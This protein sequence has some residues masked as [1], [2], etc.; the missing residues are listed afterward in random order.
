MI[1]CRYESKATEQGSSKI[2]AKRFNIFIKKSRWGRGELVRL[3]IVPNTQPIYKRMQVLFTL[4][5][6][7]LNNSAT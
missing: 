3:V 1:L 6:K 5:T 7:R 4:L 2:F